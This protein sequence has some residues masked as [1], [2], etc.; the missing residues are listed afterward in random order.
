M[1]NSGQKN[2]SSALDTQ[3]SLM[4]MD[5]KIFIAGAAGMVGSAIIRKLLCL[6][7]TNLLGSYHT[8]KP[9]A[10]LFSDAFDRAGMPRQ[11]KLVQVDLTDQASVK[12]L[13]DQERPAHVF[14]AAARVGGIHANN[15][16]PAR[17]IYENLTIQGNIIHAAYKADVNRLLF[18]GSSCIY[19]KLA[20]QPMKEQH[21]LTGLLEPTNEPYAI[22]KIAGIKM[23][24]S[25]NRQ[26][27]TRFM[28]VMPTNLYGTNDNFDLNNSH[29]LPALIRKFHLARLAANGDRE[30]IKKD[31]AR[32]GPIPQDIKTSLGLTQSSALNP[33]NSVVIWGTGT[34][35][36][37]F[38][39]VDDMADACVHIMN[40]N[41]ET[42]SRE[43]LRH[44]KPCFVNIGAGVD[45]TIHELAE[46]VRDAIGFS[47]EIVYD[48]SKPDGTPQKLLD[49]SRLSDLG[50]RSEIDL[51]DGIQKTYEWYKKQLLNR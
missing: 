13:F 30:G 38:L 36:R 14:L 5:T 10:S 4:P 35:K 20:P 1:T 34:P 29:V 32:F 19:P 12:R 24:E 27:G 18:L 40:L 45:G 6:G 51:K 8:H 26:Y 21:L 2:Q 3:Q 47:G 49:V 42:A 9:D 11:L 22:A 41:D 17:F 31:E 16:Y 43:L 39:H 7:Y 44:P 33:R 15:T 25:Y 46:I 23:C 28:A 50:W 37:E 48:Q